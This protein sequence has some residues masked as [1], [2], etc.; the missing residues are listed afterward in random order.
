[1]GNVYKYISLVDYKKKRSIVNLEDNNPLKT[2]KI[3]VW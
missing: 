1:M 2:D 3:K